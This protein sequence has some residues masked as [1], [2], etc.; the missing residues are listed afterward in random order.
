MAN[1]I[2]SLVVLRLAG[3]PILHSAL[4]NRIGRD[5][6]IPGGCRIEV[7]RDVKELPKADAALVHVDLTHVPERFSQRAAQYPIAIN[8]AVRDISKRRVC[9]TLVGPDDAYEG[10]VIVKTDFNHR[11]LPERRIGLVQDDW[12]WLLPPD[13]YP[14]FARKAD[15]PARVWRDPGL[16]VQRLH[17]E[18]Q[19]KFYVNRNWYF[20][21][22]RDIVTT[23][24]RSDP[25]EKTDT[26]VKRLPLSD[27]VPDALRRRRAKLGFDYG[28]FDFV[29]ENGEAVLL[30]A[31][32]TPHDAEIDTEGTGAIC[33]HLAGGLDSFAHK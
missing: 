5:F 31:N 22:D 17:V 8:A 18:R 12:S 33:R 9:T 15:V 32:A 10:P 29:I 1:R 7:H 23:F 21:G 28:K 27:D 13:R 6:W 19:G 24:Y 25:V 4:L 14:V 30:D 26:E 11:A 20:L 3:Q 16:V 2:T